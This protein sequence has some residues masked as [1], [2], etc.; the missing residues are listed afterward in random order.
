MVYEAL[1]AAE[2]LATEGI[3]VEVIDPRTLNP[4][5]R[6]TFIRSVKKRLLSDRQTIAGAVA[7]VMRDLGADPKH[8]SS[9]LFWP[10][11]AGEQ[12]LPSAKN[13]T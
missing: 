7:D 9:L 3:S 10:I 12:T 1:D 13:Q 2:D 11:G 6:K 4:L 8:K 5:D